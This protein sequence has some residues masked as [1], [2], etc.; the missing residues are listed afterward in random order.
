MRPR[1]GERAV[2]V[3]A[4]TGEETHALA[5]GVGPSGLA[6]GL[7]PNPGLRA[8]AAQRAARAG[9]AARFVAGDVYTLPFD[10]RTVD[11]IRCERVFQHLD[12]PDRAAAEIA[13]VLRPGGRAMV[14][15]SD[16]GTMVLR[17]GAETAVETVRRFWLGRFPNPGP[18]GG[19]AANSPPRGWWSTTP[20]REP[21]P[22]TQPAPRAC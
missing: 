1:P 22:G 3:G 18:A 8:V 17:P 9:S 15:D 10:D 2:D 4:G 21:E 11:L 5:A 16:W 12:Q 14:S 20:V 13:R 7:E 19:C 6:I